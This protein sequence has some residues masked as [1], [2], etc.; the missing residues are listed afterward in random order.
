MRL[1]QEDIQDV[2]QVYQTQGARKGQ[3]IV[4]HVASSVMLSPASQCLRTFAPQQQPLHP[5]CLHL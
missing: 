4:A 2:T 5:L 1:L 3:L